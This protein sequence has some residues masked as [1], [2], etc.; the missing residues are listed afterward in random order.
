MSATTKLTSS[1]GIADDHDAEVR[2]QRG[3][4]IVGDLGARRRDA[5]D[6]RAL[7]G[8]GIADQADIGE[9]LQLQAQLALFAGPAFFMLARRLMGGGGK[10]RV[11]ASAAPAARD[12]DALVG[13]A[14]SRAPAR[15]SVSS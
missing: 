11:A 12:D 8:V 6:Q 4:G 9:Q 10:A 2:L 5:R 7:A 13:D 3:E 1:G 14:R 15:R